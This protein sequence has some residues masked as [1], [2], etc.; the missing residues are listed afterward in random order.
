MSTA[1]I[2]P[3][4]LSLLTETGDTGIA[5]TKHPVPPALNH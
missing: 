4:S 3:A 2:K 1:P 5:L